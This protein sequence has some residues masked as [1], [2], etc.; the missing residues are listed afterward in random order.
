MFASNDGGT[1]RGYFAIDR[2]IWEQVTAAGIN[3]AAAY[4]VLACG[5]GQDNQTT[6]WSKEAIKRYA[7]VGWERARAALGA[8][9]QAGFV[10]ECDDHTGAHPHYRI[11]TIRDMDIWEGLQH[12][13]KRSHRGRSVSSTLT[14]E[15]I[16][17][18]ERRAPGDPR[19]HRSVA[20]I[21]GVTTPQT[22]L[23]SPDLIWLPN[24]IITG[25]TDGE[26]TPLRRLRRAGCIWAL[27]LFVELYGSQNL[28]DDCGIS[29]G[30]IVEEF[31][32]RKVGE[33]GA[34][35]IWGFKSFGRPIS[36][37]GL[38]AAH[39]ARTAKGAKNGPPV[40]E[41]I[42]L[43][44]KMGLVSFVPHIFENETAFAEPI[45]PFGIGGAAEVPAEQEIGRAAHDAA[46]MMALPGKIEE[47]EEAGFEYFCP[48]LNTI[49]SARMVGVARLTYRPQTRRTATW[50]AELQQNAPG[51]IK[52]FQR[53]TEE[54]EDIADGKL[55]SSRT[56]RRRR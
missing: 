44:E 46:R 9:F 3:P 32:R 1:H 22:T 33:Q 43:L 16:A 8:L 18:T 51:W 14:D 38:L 20:E 31:E 48:I 7:G 49:P 52:N 2:R 54:A 42:E 12:P 5:T 37:T 50:F 30:V 6:R 21:L 13:Q 26:E 25:T 53:L 40:L 36:R 17:D 35:T 10:G 55:R 4:L 28:R 56:G 19:R 45:H 39:Q 27:R 34:Y 15:E 47:A 24:A 29:P 11:R 41:S 23:A